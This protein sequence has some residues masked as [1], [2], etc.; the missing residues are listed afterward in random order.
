MNFYQYGKQIQRNKEAAAREARQVAMH[1][2]QNARG[3]RNV[4]SHLIPNF[5]N[6]AS[7]TVVP[8][9]KAVTHSLGKAGPKIPAGLEEYTPGP[10]E[11]VR[12]VYS[13]KAYKPVA[14]G[15][16]AETAIA[17]PQPSARPTI[18]GYPPATAEKELIIGN[19]NKTLYDMRFDPEAGKLYTKQGMA[20]GLGQRTAL[21]ELRIY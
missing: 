8:E 20:Y 13:G 15:S 3:T 5:R 6:V 4:A 14:T 7:H 9:A 12:H 11:A 19:P 16:A 17:T 1:L 10:G 2:I 21:N 18:H